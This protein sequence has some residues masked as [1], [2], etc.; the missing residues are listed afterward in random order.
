MLKTYL[1]IPVTP[2][3]QYVVSCLC[4]PTSPKGPLQWQCTIKHLSDFAIVSLREAFDEPMHKLRKCYICDS[5]C[6]YEHFSNSI[7]S[8]VF[9]DDSSVS[10]EQSSVEHK[11]YSLVCYV[12]NH[13]SVKVNL[14]QLQHT[15]PH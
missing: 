13:C 4:E 12:S 15:I 6:P 14:G 9:E 7:A 2:S 1:P 3:G 8:L 5:G 10:I 11:G